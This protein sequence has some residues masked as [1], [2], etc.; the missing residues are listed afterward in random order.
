MNSSQRLLLDPNLEPEQASDEQVEEVPRRRSTR[1]S[2][3]SNI[4]PSKPEEEIH[5][6]PETNEEDDQN[7]LKLGDKKDTK[8]RKRKTVIFERK[9]RDRKKVKVVEKEST[10]PPVLPKKTRSRGRPRKEPIH[11]EG[12]FDVY[13]EDKTPEPSQIPVNVSI[14]KE[15]DPVPKEVFEV[16]EEIHID[17]MNESGEPEENPDELYS[18]NNTSGL[19]RSVAIFGLEDEDEESEDDDD[20]TLSAD[21]GDYEQNEEA[22]VFDPEELMSEEFS[23][24]QGQGSFNYQYPYSMDEDDENTQYSV[25]AELARYAREDALMELRSNQ[26]MTEGDFDFHEEEDPE[27]QHELEQLANM[28]E[29]EVEYYMVEENGENIYYAVPKTHEEE[30]IERPIPPM[31][32][33]P[34][35]PRQGETNRSEYYRN[36][37]EK[38]EEFYY[39]EG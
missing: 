35:H 3:K 9:K 33:D 18:E 1:N 34:D 31:E 24:S 7:E 37:E 15:K 5:K 8:K 25:E 16:V 23:N 21:P 10:A 29:S 14:K 22:S 12:E 20:R 26:E 11:F 19:G 17:K 39:E 27:I 38:T 30:I 36:Y 32:F 2:K 13:D 28:N 6:N 4:Q